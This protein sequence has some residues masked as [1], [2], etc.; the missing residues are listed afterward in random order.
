MWLANPKS[1]IEQ[2]AG[3]F[4]VLFINFHFISLFLVW[5]FSLTCARVPPVQN[6]STLPF[7]ENKLPVVYG[8]WEG[9]IVQPHG[10][11]NSSLPSQFVM[12]IPGLLGGLRSKL[13]CFLAIPTASLG[14]SS[15]DS[16]LLAQLPS[17]FCRFVASSLFSL[18]FFW[19]VCLKNSLPSFTGLGEGVEINEVFN[20]S[21][22]FL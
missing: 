3:G 11:G 5:Y 14:F 6:P 10:I 1:R 4:E 9:A 21:F 15:L 17:S 20:L 19:W 22:Y 12:S 7:S 13:G 2:R 8:D 16:Y 18:L